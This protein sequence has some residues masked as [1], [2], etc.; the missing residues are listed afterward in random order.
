M[1]KIG[2]ILDSTVDQLKSSYVF[3]DASD[4]SLS[5]I[6]AE[7]INHDVNQMHLSNKLPTN[8]KAY[9]DKVTEFIN[10]GF[11]HVLIITSSQHLTKSYETALLVKDILKDKVIDIIDSKSFG[12]GILYLLMCFK[13][14]HRKNYAYQ[15]IT[16]LIKIQVDKGL[17]LIVTSN[18][19]FGRD[20][21]KVKR[22]LKPFIKQ[23]ILSSD[24]NYHV[25]QVMYHKQKT[26]ATLFQQLLGYKGF[27]Q[28]INVFVYSGFNGA[29]AKLLQHE[30]FTKYKD[31]NVNL[32]GALSKELSTYFGADAYGIYLG[33]Y[34]EAI[35]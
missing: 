30:L 25:Q 12:P 21:I 17:T 19:Q 3:K 11:E 24:S 34:E 32:Y 4:V 13:L 16:E 31:L 18:H 35:V 6:H 20:S 10:D 28:K 23:Y 15:K 9:M 1:N 5:F 27:K 14:W 29:E 26:K 2:I 22:L 7:V 33:Y 8:F